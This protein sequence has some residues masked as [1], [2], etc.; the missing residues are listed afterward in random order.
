MIKFRKIIK[1]Q[2][3]QNMNKIKFLLVA[4]MIAMCA[5]ATS[6]AKDEVTTE[7]Q[8]LDAVNDKTA[9]Y[10][11]TSSMTVTLTFSNGGKTLAFKMMASADDVMLSFAEGNAKNTATTGVYTYDETTTSSTKGDERAIVLSGDNVGMYKIEDGVMAETA[12][13]TFAWDE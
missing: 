1:I 8:F 13:F 10:V 5:F 6:C 2:G 4:M 7:E 9:S 12:M 3:V 11:M